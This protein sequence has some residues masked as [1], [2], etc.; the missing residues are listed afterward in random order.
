MSC[1]TGT[2]SRVLR[3]SNRGGGVAFRAH[4]GGF[5]AGALLIFPFR[6]RALV[7]RHPYHGWTPRAGAG[8]ARLL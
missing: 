8:D 2:T 1:S 4:I 3:W 5:A 6:N 7:D